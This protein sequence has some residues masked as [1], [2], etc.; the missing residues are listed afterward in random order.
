MA[1]QDIYIKDLD[2]FR[3]YAGRFREFGS[4]VRYE[5]DNLI[6]AAEE[7]VYDAEQSYRKADD[8]LNSII[9]QMNRLRDALYSAREGDVN[10]ALLYE[11]QEKYARLG[12]VKE[13]VRNQVDFLWSYYLRIKREVNLLT[14]TTRGYQE[15]I[16]TM[17]D[18][19]SNFLRLV[20]DKA[21]NYMDIR[22]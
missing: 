20:E 12:H 5:C 10:P 11:A 7:S 17:T 3:I 4:N 21:R 19:G 15:K 9:S 1:K 22:K 18:N 13:L 2:G 16:T 8:I 14:D 6:S